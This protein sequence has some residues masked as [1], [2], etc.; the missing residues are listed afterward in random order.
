MVR[1]RSRFSLASFSRSQE[2][3]ADQ[4]GVK[5][6]AR[7]GLRSVRRATLPHVARPLRRRNG[8]E[9]AG[10][11]P[12]CSPPIRAR[13]NAS[14]GLASGPARERARHR[15]SRSRS[16]SRRRRRAGLRRR[17]GRRDHP[18][19]SLHPWPARRRL[20]GAGGLHPR[21]HLAGRAR[22]VRRRQPAP[23]VR[24]RR[25]AR[26][27]RA[28][29]RCCARP[30]TIRSRPGRLE[31]TTVNG[32]PVATRRL[33]RQGMVVPPLGHPDR[34]H[35]LPADPRRRRRSAA[36]SR[37]C[38]GATLGGRSG[39]SRRTEARAV[40]PLRLQVVTAGEGDTVA[41][42]GR[43]HGGKRPAARAIH[44]S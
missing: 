7:A 32:L 16:L 40:R 3:E 43:A 24:R 33:A 22:S 27:G 23:A 38:S 36:T 5:V 44:R 12:T 34:R 42:L 1:D 13:R 15:R 20:R 9:P 19:P 39:R 4:A 8:P 28:S 35:D 31:T 41:S 25:H 18:R 29:R 14:P 2:L 11:S 30:G 21:E 6:L 10:R 37:R 17:S 26:T